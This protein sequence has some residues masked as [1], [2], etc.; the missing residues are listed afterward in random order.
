MASPRPA[1]RPRTGSTVG[2][3]LR[4][5]AG[6][7]DQLEADAADHLRGQDALI[8]ES[9]AAAARAD[10]DIGLADLERQAGAV[11]NNGRGGDAAVRA[12][13]AV[14]VELDTGCSRSGSAGARATKKRPHA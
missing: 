13:A 4:E 8:A 6:G 5:L 12:E 7:N 2:A 9:A 14:L 10:R 3:V 1:H 11:G